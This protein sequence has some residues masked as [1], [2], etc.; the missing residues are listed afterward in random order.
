MRRRCECTCRDRP[1]EENALL[2]KAV[3]IWACVRR[4][5]VRA[6]VV[7]TQSIDR[8]EKDIRR[9]LFGRTAE[10]GPRQEEGKAGLGEHRDTSCSEQFP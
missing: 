6:E 2:G 7:G 9:S 5:T 1:F 8:H 10:G 3:D 4:E